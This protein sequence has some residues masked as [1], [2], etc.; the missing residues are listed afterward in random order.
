MVRDYSKIVINEM[1]LPNQGASVIATQI[2]MA[3]LSI[4]GGMERT[5]KQWHELLNSVGLKIVHVWMDDQDAEAV[6]E[7]ELK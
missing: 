4:L 6:I 3:M 7:A 5:E 2:D 1:V